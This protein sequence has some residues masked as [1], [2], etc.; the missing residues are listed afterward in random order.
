[1][2]K[3]DGAIIRNSSINPPKVRKF[4]LSKGNEPVTSLTLV[5]T[6]LSTTTKWA[7]NLASGGQLK[8]AM[9]DANIDEL[10]HLSMVINGK[11]TVEK[12]EVINVVQ[13]SSISNKS[14]TLNIPV[15]SGITINQ[16]FENTM[17]LMGTRYGTYDAE[18]NNC[19]V[20]IDS[21]LNANGLQTGNSGI[22]LR[23]K[24]EELFRKFPSLTKF[25]TDAVTT[26]GAIVDRQIQG[27][28]IKKKRK[29]KYI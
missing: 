1:M 21:M 14:E 8:Q 29:K 13:K 24:T 5:R 7:L 16:L 3:G 15:R 28:G 23:Q 18:N 19:S 12:N 9:R 22:F 20:F 26:A 2:I 27:E 4:L 10:F 25:I 11:Y 6:P 17:R